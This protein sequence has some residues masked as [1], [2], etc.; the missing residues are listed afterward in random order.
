MV[1]T[2]GYWGLLSVQYI[3][4]PSSRKKSQIL[5]S[6]M[7]APFQPTTLILSKERISHKNVYFYAKWKEASRKQNKFFVCA[8]RELGCC[9]YVFVW[10]PEIDLRMW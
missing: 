5:Q 7:I 4:V 1:F 8:I 3:F 2:L 10:T 9:L 6:N